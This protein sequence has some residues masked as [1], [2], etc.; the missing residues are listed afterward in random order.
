MRRR[1]WACILLAAS[2]FASGWHTA[3]AYARPQG[4][5]AGWE[6]AVTAESKQAEGTR[7]ES[8]QADTQAVG[9]QSETVQEE[10]SRDSKAG[11]PQEGW[12]EE[13]EGSYTYVVLADQ[14]VKI[15]KYQGSGWDVQ[16]PSELGGHTVSCIGEYAFSSGSMAQVS[17]PEGVRVIEK[18][19]F[20]QCAGLHA[21]SFPASLESIGQG[22]FSSCG[23]AS[24]TLPS[25]IEEVEEGA[26]A[27]N[28]LLYGVSIPEGVT[29][30]K[31]Q[32]FANNAGLSEVKL[33][34][35]LYKVEEQAFEGCGIF[36]IWL[37]EGSYAEQYARES[38]RVCRYPQEEAEH[39]YIEKEIQQPSDGDAG[40]IA[41]VCQGCGDTYARVLPPLG[42]Q[43]EGGQPQE[44]QEEG[45]QPGQ[46]LEEKETDSLG[47][48]AAKEGGT[49]EET[50]AGST[51]SRKKGRVA[52]EAA[53][54][55]IVIHGASA[56]MRP[57]SRMQLSVTGNGSVEGAI[58]W[59]SSSR[60]TVSISRTGEAFAWKAGSVVITARSQAG[61]TAQYRISVSGSPTVSTPKS[62]SQALSGLA[63]S[64]RSHNNYSSY[65]AGVVNSYLMEDKGGTF[66]RVENIN[67]PGRY[68]PA[69]KVVLETYDS[70]TKKLVRKKEIPTELP[71]FGGFYSGEQYNFL[72]YGQGNTKE[73]DKQE[74]LRVVKYTKEW[75]RLGSVSAYG[76]NTSRPFEAGSLRMAEAGGSLYIHT[77]HQ[78]Y[79]SM[80][81][82]RHQANMTFVVDEGK[83][84]ITQ[85]VIWVANN[86]SGYVSHS[87][88]QFVQTDGTHIYRAD[89]G[90]GAP[91]G[92]MI[93]KCEVGG[94]IVD[95]EWI[96]PFTFGGAWGQNST[97]ASIGGFELSSDSCLIAGNSVPQGKDY[98]GTGGQRNI[99][100]TVAGK[101]MESS[102][103]VWV[104]A[105]KGGETEV[106]T[107][108]LVKIGAD[109]FLLMWEEKN[110]KS[111]KIVTKIAAMDGDA[112]LVSGIVSCRLPLSDCKPVVLKNGQVQ[113][114]VT[115]DSKPMLYSISPLDLKAAKAI[116]VEKVSVTGISKQ[117][118][119]GK[120]LRLSAKVTPKNATNPSI[121][122]KS[123]NT[124]VAVVSKS[125]LVTMKKGSGGKSVKITAIAQDGSGVK[126]VY[127]ISSQKGVVKKISISGQKTVKA[128][129][130][131][132]LK[133]KVTAS[134]GANKKLA[135]KSGNTKYATVSSSGKV[136]AKPAGRGKKVKITAQATDGSGKKKTVTVQIKK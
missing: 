63:S 112:Q 85:N 45:S 10:N 124:K 5:A 101:D 48:P 39:A 57:G 58:Q 92:A 82:L 89:H 126:A 49:A 4:G 60:K 66:T 46:P 133:A 61:L 105:Y 96:T 107:P 119:A 88:N 21:V 128:G 111:G 76:A 93:S 53:A 135:W 3:F 79:K 104:T 35:T 37:Q 73:S 12:Q 70:K 103:T 95:V 36:N 90:D 33:P 81:G 127:K 23:L 84:E 121:Q 118:A 125:G 123:S 100:V 56:S 114:Y 110:S 69:E 52:R 132:Q 109:Q 122:W 62:H 102:H 20:S 113:W 1:R 16:I 134:K 50:Q 87:L 30:I 38:H 97:G 116:Q 78:M 13:T 6:A 86:S 44:S 83:M 26:F 11:D 80:D 129:K 115:E 7:A 74:I 9:G 18:Y 94:R 117:I 15:T 22:A 130:A 91:R 14:T 106:R 136:K 43:T 28:L 75:K 42:S 98:Q 31:G 71:I 59:S 27:D 25:G 8:G 47:N 99:F 51:E 19:A 68:A 41:Y 72:I 40:V 67:K 54:T 24:V 77:C 120:K 64:N 17:L 32:A 65:Y 131:L 2:L 34:A 29:E 108:H 55:Q